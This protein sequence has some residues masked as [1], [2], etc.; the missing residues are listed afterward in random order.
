MPVNLLFDEN[1]NELELKNFQYL[2]ILNSN[3]D[4]KF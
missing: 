2:E 1:L 4:K 3:L